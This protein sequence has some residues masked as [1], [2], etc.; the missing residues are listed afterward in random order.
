M[1]AV[2]ILSG[3]A[4]DAAVAMIRRMPESEVTDLLKNAR[5]MQAEG[6]AFEESQTVSRAMEIISWV[7]EARG[8]QARK[9]EVFNIQTKTE[10]L[11]IV[12]SRLT[13][14]EA[15]KVLRDAIAKH[16]QATD[17]VRKLAAG[18]S[19]T[20]AMRG[21]LHYLANHPESLAPK[22]PEGK[23]IGQP[24]ERIRFTATIQRATPRDG[25][26]GPQT[27][28]TMLTPEGNTIVWFASGHQDFLVGEQ[29]TFDGL[30]KEHETYRGRNQTI[31]TKCRKIS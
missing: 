3:V 27:V 7:E 10:G 31:V 25:R 19:L 12:E 5:A 1:V 2:D 11:K 29:V 18:G 16:G 14:A 8:G 24:G 28:L 17:F 22:A 6:E 15:I 23:H 30:V 9:P 4:H 20:P 13:D 26:Y 21:W